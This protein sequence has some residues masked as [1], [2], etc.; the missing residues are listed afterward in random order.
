MMQK[1]QKKI[2]AL[3]S[4][5]NTKPSLKTITPLLQ[6]YHPNTLAKTN[7]QLS[8]SLVFISRNKNKNVY[9]NIVILLVFWVT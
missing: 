7:T 8:F 3:I 9:A 6:L 4:R 5:D 2:I 1:V